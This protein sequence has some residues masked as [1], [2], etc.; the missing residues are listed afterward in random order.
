M[1]YD[2]ILTAVLKC[3]GRHD[4]FLAGKAATLAATSSFYYAKSRQGVGFGGLA[5]LGEPVWSKNSILNMY[6]QS[7]AYMVL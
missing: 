2:F 5:S 3:Q 6:R 1:S 4:H 7:S